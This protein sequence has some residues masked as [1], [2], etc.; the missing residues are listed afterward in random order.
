MTIQRCS[1]FQMTFFL[2]VCHHPWFD[3]CSELEFGISRP[4]LEQSSSHECIFERWVECGCA[5]LR[6]WHPNPNRKLTSSVTSTDTHSFIFA[7][8]LYSTFYV[9]PHP[10]PH[11]L[12]FYQI[13]HEF[14]NS[15]EINCCG[16]PLQLHVASLILDSAIQSSVLIDLARMMFAFSTCNHF[17]HVF[18]YTGTDVA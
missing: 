14:R 9:L 13:P 5:D 4:L 1:T 6:M 3:H 8:H 18:R 16:W 7:S 17:G 15:K 11:M 10:Q 2:Y 12:V